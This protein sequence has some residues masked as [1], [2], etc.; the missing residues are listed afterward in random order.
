MCCISAP[1]K[2]L[3][4]RECQH[5]TYKI[6]SSLRALHANVGVPLASSSKT[7]TVTVARAA[8]SVSVGARYRSAHTGGVTCSD[9]Q[10]CSPD[11]FCEHGKC[12]IRHTCVLCDPVGNERRRHIRNAREFATQTGGWPFQHIVV[13]PQGTYDTVV[14]IKVEK[15]VRD[16][17]LK[18]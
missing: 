17:S 7:G 10:L 13:G 15:D 5:T 1:C 14:G 9:C 18:W 2:S 3:L 11:K 12:K 8:S 16:A 4:S 6:A